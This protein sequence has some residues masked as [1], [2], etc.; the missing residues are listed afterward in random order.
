MLAAEAEAAKALGG[1]SFGKA[2][3]STAETMSFSFGR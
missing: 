2:N 3:P 1:L